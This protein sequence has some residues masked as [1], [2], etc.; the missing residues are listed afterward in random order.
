MSVNREMSENRV[1]ENREPT[2]LIKVKIRGPLTR[3]APDVE[4]EGTKVT[5]NVQ[6]W[7]EN[8]TF[9]RRKDIGQKFV[10]PTLMLLPIKRMGRRNGRIPRPKVNRRNHLM[11]TRLLACVFQE[12]VPRPKWYKSMWKL[13]VERKDKWIS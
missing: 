1:S 13:D 12:W 11:I 7:R 9:V 5:R 8:A 6:R 10:D 4:E 3:I 2:V